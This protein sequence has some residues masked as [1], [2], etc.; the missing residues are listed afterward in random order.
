MLLQCLF[1]SLLAEKK[2]VTQTWGTLCSEYFF[3]PKGSGSRHRQKTLISQDL[4][5][6][7]EIESGVISLCKVKWEDSFNQQR[8]TDL[9]GLHGPFCLLSNQ[10]WNERTRE[11]RWSIPSY[12][13]LN[14]Q[15]RGKRSREKLE[16]ICYVP[17]TLKCSPSRCEEMGQLQA[18]L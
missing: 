9:Y 13:K 16:Q 11:D 10:S 6:K 4:I 17:I 3:V 15:C 7:C 2:T 18:G 1:S 12:Y 8:K 14:F 5:E